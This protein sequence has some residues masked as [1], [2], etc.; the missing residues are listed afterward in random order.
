MVFSIDPEEAER[1]VSNGQAW[2]EFCD[3]LRNAGQA[4][5]RPGT[6]EDA[7]TRA[8]GL[9][10]LT[11]I[12]R[13]ALQTFVEHADPAAPVLQSVVHE[14][15]K[16]G[17]DNPDNF[18]QNAA[19][20]GAHTYRIWGRRGTVQWLEFA[21]QQGHYGAGRGMPPTGH[22]DARDMAIDADGSFEIWLSVEPREGNWLPMTKD[23]GTLIVRQS[24]LDPSTEV[25]AEVHI[26]RVGGDGRP[27]PLTPETMVNGLRQVG[28]LVNGAS[29]LFCEWAEGFTAHTN[30][31]PRFDQ[32]LSDSMG[33][34]PHIAY[35]HSYW[36][37]GPDECLVIEAT[38]PPCDH[39][40]FQLNNHWMESLDYRYDQIHL[41]SA[42][43]TIEADGS[44]RL[45]VAHEDPGHPNWIRTV[46]HERGTMCF[47][48]VRPEVD[49][50][51]E[52]RCRVM[53]LEAARAL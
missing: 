36:K 26:E 47:R 27:T 8:E 44:I 45:V 41:N 21:T 7:F 11:R 35:Y 37:L 33:G 15:A 32:A 18:Y 10:Y 42:T 51:P 19:I 30:Q 34:V 50:P 2:D 9:R 3:M 52:P 1:M 12:T 46:G 5:S 43:A 38:P 24:Q 20:S 23:S 29:M 13:A 31:L 39:W 4:L 40:N 17:A 49:D 25:L 14:T 16:M 53:S 28:M 22:L 48:W 6:P